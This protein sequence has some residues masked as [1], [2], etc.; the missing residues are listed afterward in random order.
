VYRELESLIMDGRLT[1]SKQVKKQ[2][3]MLQRNISDLQTRIG[4]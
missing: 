2:Q 3:D 4:K 1:I